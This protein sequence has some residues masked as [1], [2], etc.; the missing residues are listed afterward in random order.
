MGV[1]P[2]SFESAIAAEEQATISSLATTDPWFPLIT[3]GCFLQRE[4]LPEIVEIVQ[5]IVGEQSKLVIGSGSKSFKTWLTI[6]M[7]LCIAAGIPFLGRETQREAVLYVNLE[8]KPITFTRRV[9]AIAKAL[10]IDIPGACFFHLPLRGKLARA[11]LSDVISRLIRL[12]KHHCAKVIVLDPVYKLNVDG[13]ENSSRDMTKFFNELDRLTTESGCTVII[14]DHFGKGNQSEKD[15]LDAI[16]GSS[17]KAG[18]LDAAMVLRK[19]EVDDCFRVDVIHRELAPVEPFVMGWEFPLM[20]LRPDLSADAMKKAKGGRKKAFDPEQ[21][22]AAIADATAE[23]PVSITAWAQSVG[24]TRQ[25][26]QGYLP[27]LRSK[28]WVATAGEGSS[29]RQFL[30]EKGQSAARRYSGGCE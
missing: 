12:A 23:N 8:L 25:T 20:R 9:Q 3:D 27:G 30:T 11:I 14:N 21:L 10:G 29:A 4:H 24:I 18:D 2:V 19:H 15:P 7:A 26:L 1:H 17:A 16:R 6:H 28:G 5:G 13:E 22:C